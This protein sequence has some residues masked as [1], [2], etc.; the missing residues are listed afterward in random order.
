MSRV[1]RYDLLQAVSWHDAEEV[2]S[3][4]RKAKRQHI[5]LSDRI[6]PTL[7]EVIRSLYNHYP[8]P[9]KE[10]FAERYWQTLPDVAYEILEL[11]RPFYDFD[12]YVKLYQNHFLYQVVL[13]GDIRMLEYLWTLDPMQYRRPEYQL[14][15]IFR[16]AV[17]DFCYMRLPDW[18]GLPHDKDIPAEM[19]QDCY[20][21]D[22]GAKEW[23]ETLYAQAE[24]CHIAPP[25][26]LEFLL[27][28]DCTLNTSELK[29]FPSR[30]CLELKVRCGG[31]PKERRVWEITDGCFMHNQG[32]DCGEMVKGCLRD[33][34]YWPLTCVCGFPECAGVTEPV[35]ALRFGDVAR[36]RVTS[37]EDDKAPSVYY[38]AVPVTDYLRNMDMLLDVVERGIGE[39]GAVPPDAEDGPDHPTTDFS[40]TPNSLKKVQTLRNLIRKELSGEEIPEF[41]KKPEPIT[42]VIDE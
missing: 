25:E 23:L 33:G 24:R 30:S 26:H 17:E 40:A 37:S 42:I 14:G 2:R 4:L 19:S 16:A 39:D 8:Q 15:Q 41:E 10:P 11:L 34:E 32:Q 21:L 35:L 38:R 5:P 1:S 20:F 18:E 9:G 29:L 22:L 28:H 36:W 3:L 6:Y 31:S 7:P 27:K 12:E 13:H